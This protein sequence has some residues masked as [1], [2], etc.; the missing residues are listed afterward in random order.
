ME[1]TDKYWIP[2]FNIPEKNNIRVTLSH[3][4]CT[5]HQK[6]N[7]TDCKDAKWI[8]NLYMYGMVKPYFIPPADICE[9]RDL[10]RYRYKLTY[11]ITDGKNLTQNC[12]TI[13]NLKLDGSFFNVFG[14]SSSS[15]TEQILQHPGKTFNI[16]PF[17]DSRKTPIEE[18]QAAADGAI[19]TKQ[20]VKLRQCLNH[21]DELEMHKAKIEQEI[22]RLSDKYEENLTRIRTVSGFDKN[23]IAAIQV[24]SEIGGDM[25]VFSQLNT[26]F[27]GPYVVLTTIKAI[28]KSNPRNILN[29]LLIIDA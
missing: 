25:S 9:L 12:L 27:H 6:D 28:K 24:L 11:M 10:V 17:V 5:K 22:F 23:P 20:A 21:F 13:S 26:S 16:V 2:V 18:I 1:S 7:K 15:I 4:E 19:S 3:P 14:K 8:C 29:L